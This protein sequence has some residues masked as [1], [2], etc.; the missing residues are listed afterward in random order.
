MQFVDPVVE[1]LDPK[2]C[3]RYRLSKAATK[4]QNGKHYRVWHFQLFAYFLLFEI[5]CLE[6]SAFF[7][8]PLIFIL[9]SFFL[10]PFFLGGGVG[11][12]VMRGG[13]WVEPVA[14]RLGL[15]V[16]AN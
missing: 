12:G 9:L 16:G 7:L 3:I 13:S 15:W 14:H 6:F 1:R 10:F 5:I 11:L 8:F 2:H 4:Y